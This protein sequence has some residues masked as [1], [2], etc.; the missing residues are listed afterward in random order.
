MVKVSEK[1]KM[2]QIIKNANAISLIKIMVVKN[3][4]YFNNF[5]YEYFD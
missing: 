1:S 2:L 5:V 3:N 4:E